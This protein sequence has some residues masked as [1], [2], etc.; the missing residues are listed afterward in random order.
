MKIK[1]S[2]ARFGV[3]GAAMFA[4]PNRNHHSVKSGILETPLRIKTIL[5]LLNR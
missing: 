5:R 2:P 3:G 4:A 1:I